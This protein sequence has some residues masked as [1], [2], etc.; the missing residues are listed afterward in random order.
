MTAEPSID[1]FYLHRF[2]EEHRSDITGDVLE[3]QVPGYTR[4][5]GI[6]VRTSHTVDIVSEFS[7]TFQCDLA[8]ADGHIPSVAYDCFLLPN[9]LQHLKHIDGA[10]R[11]AFRV[12]KPGG[13]ILASAAGLL[14]LTS[15]SDDYWRLSPAGWRELTAGA[16]PNAEIAISAHGNCLSAAA[17][18]YGLAVEELDTREL[19]VQDE[20]FPVLITI[21]CQKPAAPQDAT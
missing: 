9:T 6:D 5:F 15:A 4:Q 11:Q 1:R 21:R 14:R 2:L 7:P 20:R 13:V 16:W 18:I 12:L 10:L 8:N 3:I 17:A 19:V